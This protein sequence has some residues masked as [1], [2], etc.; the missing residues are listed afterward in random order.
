MWMGSIHERSPT[1]PQTGAMIAFDAATGK[2]VWE[3]KAIRPMRGSVLTT[4]GDL[5]FYGDGFGYLVA[6]HARSGEIL[7]KMNT[8]ARGITAPPMT[9][10]MDGKQHIAVLAGGA[11]FDYVLPEP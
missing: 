8:G 11:M 2:K 3:Q 7:W 4:A 1:Y 10:L 9:Y 6:Y 5:V